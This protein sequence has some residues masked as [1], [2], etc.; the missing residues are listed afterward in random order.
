MIKALKRAEEV[1]EKYRI[2]SAPI[3]LIKIIKGEC[4][5]LK[6]WHFEG[7]VKEVYLGDFIGLKKGLSISERRELIAHALGHHFFKTVWGGLTITF[8][9]PLIID[10]S[11]NMSEKRNILPH[12][13]WCQE[14]CCGKLKVCK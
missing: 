12:F 4:I 3:D 11:K 10:L 7:R 5:N 8:S 13:S 9:P 14:K 6:E 2:S 1:L